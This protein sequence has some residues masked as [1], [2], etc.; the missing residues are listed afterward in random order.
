MACQ[1][2]TT[3]SLFHGNW[4]RN[5]IL[6]LWAHP[7][8]LHTLPF[9]RV[10]PMLLLSFV[11]QGQKR[12]TGTLSVL[13]ISALGQDVFNFSSPPPTPTPAFFFSHQGTVRG[14][15]KI[16]LKLTT[17]L[18]ISDQLNIKLVNENI[19]QHSQVFKLY[20]S[21]KQGNFSGSIIRTY[22][23]VKFTS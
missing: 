7:P 9:F 13:F 5:L 17:A 12:H 20:H 21:V 23:W 3:G 4:R 16:I 19:S 2:F 6:N 18:T 15:R 11:D 14:S 8:P 10:C 22:E 1:M